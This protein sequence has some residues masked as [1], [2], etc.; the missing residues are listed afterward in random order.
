M[1]LIVK[2]KTTTV[3]NLKTIIDCKTNPLIIPESPWHSRKGA[4]N[5][6]IITRYFELQ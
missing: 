3:I 6:R 2:S 5:E 4:N 1:E